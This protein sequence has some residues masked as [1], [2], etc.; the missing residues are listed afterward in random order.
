MDGQMIDGLASAHRRLRAIGAIAALLAFLPSMAVSAA[1]EN[2]GSCKAC[3]EYNR[4]CLQAHSKQACKSELD[5]C[6]KHCERK[7]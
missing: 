1:A 7:R 4:A 6:L 5:M 2:L 3:R